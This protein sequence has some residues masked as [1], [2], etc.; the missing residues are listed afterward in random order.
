MIEG[1]IKDLLDTKAEYYEHPSFIE[2][3][4][5]KIPHQFSKKEDI[6]ISGFLTA[7]IAWGNRKAIL[8]SAEKMMRCMDHAP[9]DFV[10]NFK[11]KDLKPFQTFVHRTFNGDDFIFFVHAIRHI[12]EHHGGLENALCTPE[13]LNTL[14][15]ISLFKKLFFEPEHLKRTQKHVSD[16]RKGSAAKRINMFLR[17]MVRS[18]KKG[19]DFGIWNKLNPSDLFLPLDVHT[20][21]QARKLNLL[22]RKQNDRKAVDE[23]TENLRAFDPQDPV[24]YDYALFGMGVFEKSGF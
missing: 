16:P 4:P 15:R 14:D 8:N 3:D 21:N 23:L 11:L 17:W 2:T 10:M 22:K 19:V 20:A 12:Y 7:T 1:D 24:K 13:E 18:D 6:E 9:H 5:I